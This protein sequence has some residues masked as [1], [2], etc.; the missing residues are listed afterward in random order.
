M[1]RNLFA[2]LAA[3]GTSYS[4]QSRQSNRHAVATSAR[5]GELLIGGASNSTFAGNMSSVEE[6]KKKAAIA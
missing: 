4:R 2:A 1:T 5:R 6:A 3:A